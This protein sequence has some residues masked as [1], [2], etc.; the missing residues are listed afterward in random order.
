MI[1]KRF[2]NVKVRDNISMETKNNVFNK[3]LSWIRLI[4]AS[5]KHKVTA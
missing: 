5:R 3:I 4:R 2:K 1:G